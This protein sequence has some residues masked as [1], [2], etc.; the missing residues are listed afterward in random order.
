MCKWYA[1]GLLSSCDIVCICHLPCLFHIVLFAI[2]FAVHCIFL[3]QQHVSLTWLRLILPYTQH[4]FFRHHIASF[5][6]TWGKH[7]LPA[8]F[9]K[10]LCHT[11]YVCCYMPYKPHLLYQAVFRKARKGCWLFALHISALNTCLLSFFARSKAG[12]NCAHKPL[13]SYLFICSIR[14]LISFG[15]G[16]PLIGLFWLLLSSSD[17]FIVC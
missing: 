9:Y 2:L 10:A 17:N 5:C 3:H 16:I 6:H 1:P 11:L 8:I 7:Q 12:F 13:P 4:N 14:S 15:I